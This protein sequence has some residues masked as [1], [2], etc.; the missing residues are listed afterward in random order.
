MWFRERDAWA[1]F[2]EMR[3]HFYGQ[4]HINKSNKN[5]EISF[6][7]RKLKSWNV[8]LKQNLKSS[9]YTERITSA[10]SSYVL[11]TKL[12][13]YCLSMRY[14]A[15]KPLF[16]QI[17]LLIIRIEL[18]PGGFFWLLS[19]VSLTF[20]EIQLIIISRGSAGCKF[21]KWS[22]L[23]KAWPLCGRPILK[24]PLP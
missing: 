15:G 10:K 13:L 5:R 3:G 8:V 20:T 16:V 1:Y 17:I 6:S 9:L 12:S 4:K 14:Y 2:R 22:A 21:K 7:S 11:K 18:C 23:I 19:T 24:P